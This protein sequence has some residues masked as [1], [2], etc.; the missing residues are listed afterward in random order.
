MLLLILMLEIMALAFARPYVLQHLPGCDEMV[1]RTRGDRENGVT[2]APRL[3]AIAEDILLSQTSLGH[4]VQREGDGAVARR[5]HITGELGLVGMGVRRAGEGQEGKTAQD[6]GDSGRFADMGG[7]M[8]C[9]QTCHRK[10]L[11]CEVEKS[12]VCVL[13]VVLQCGYVGIGLI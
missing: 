9:R 11:E 13:C 12:A 5:T 1:V 7:D 2:K 8:V 6:G 3:R 10:G 4:D